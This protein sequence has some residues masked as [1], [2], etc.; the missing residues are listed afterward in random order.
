M[1]ASLINLYKLGIITKETA[2]Q[3]SPEP[4]LILGQL[5]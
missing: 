1:N 3:Y 5:K 4:E 2:V